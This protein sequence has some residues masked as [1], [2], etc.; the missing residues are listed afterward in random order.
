MTLKSGLN[1]GSTTHQL[2]ELGNLSSV[3]LGL[4]L[5]LCKV[6]MIGELRGFLNELNE[7]IHVKGLEPHLAH[8][9]SASYVLVI[10]N[11]YYYLFFHKPWIT[12]KYSKG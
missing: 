5:S 2:C 10:I 3:S 11:H 1:P 8:I 12:L 6:E 9:V 4:S 7:L